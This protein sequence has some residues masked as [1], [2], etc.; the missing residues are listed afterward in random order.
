MFV[1]IYNYAK[2]KGIK[3]QNIYR[4]IREKRL[5]EGSDYQIIEKVVKRLVINDQLDYA[6]AKEKRVSDQIYE[7]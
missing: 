3:K 4:L 5:I 7:I 6:K 2:L 1:P